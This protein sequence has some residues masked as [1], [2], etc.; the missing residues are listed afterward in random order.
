MRL[1]TSSLLILL[2]SA[3]VAVGCGMDMEPPGDGNGGGTGGGGNGG[4]GGGG[5]GGGG[6]GEVIDGA[7]FTGDVTQSGTFGGTI[8]VT[9]QATILEDVDIAIAPGSQIIAADGASLSVRGSLLVDGT[10]DQ[11]V[12]MLPAE[13]A[14]AWKGIVAEAG[15]S[16]TIR[17]ATGTLVATLLTCKA[18]AATCA[19][20]RIDF[21]HVGNII[22]ALA[23][24]TLVESRV[25]DMANGAVYVRDAGDL[26]IRDTELMQSNGDIVVAGGGRLLVE[27]SNIGGTVDTYEHCN[28][29][30]GKADAATIRYSNIVTGTYGMMIGSVDGAVVNYNNFQGNNVDINQVDAAVTAADFRYNYWDKGAPISLGPE[31]DF[32]SAAPAQLTGT[33]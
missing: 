3:A 24:A 33:G 17:Y 26:T 19:L 14:A 30:I 6:G 29:H 22:N 12:S 13:G 25:V 11:T 15:G 2:L 28:L 20:E 7:E 8:H 1:A 31:Y 9:G 23:T 21:E 27:Y 4:G 16:V 32:S 10:A 5:N 18:D